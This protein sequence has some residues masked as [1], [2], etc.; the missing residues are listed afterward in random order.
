MLFLIDYGYISKLTKSNRFIV[1]ITNVLDYL[2]I[3]L[4]RL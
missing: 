3:L 2:F 1:L 4:P